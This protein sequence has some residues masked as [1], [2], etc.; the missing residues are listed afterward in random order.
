MAT[1]EIET[2]I[3]MGKKKEKKNHDPTMEH[4]D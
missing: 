3:T 2:I 4:G 1:M